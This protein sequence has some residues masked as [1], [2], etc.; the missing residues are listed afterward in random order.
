MFTVKSFSAPWLG[1]SSKVFLEPSLGTSGLGYYVGV[2][3]K[4]SLGIFTWGQVNDIKDKVI[5]RDTVVIPETTGD[6]ISQNLVEDWAYGVSVIFSDGKFGEYTTVSIPLVGLMNDNLGA[7]VISGTAT[8][9]IKHDRFA[10]MLEDHKLR[11]LLTELKYR[12]FVTL[13]FDYHGNLRAKLLGLPWYGH[14][15]I[16][17]LVKKRGCGTGE[18]IKRYVER[19]MDCEFVEAW[20]VG[21]LLSCFPFPA[22]SHGTDPRLV[23][24]N[25]DALKHFYP[26]FDV[27]RGNETTSNVLGVA[28]GW[29]FEGYSSRLHK[30]CEYVS[31][32]CK[33]IWCPEVQY[34][35]DLC[36]QFSK[37]WGEIKD[38]VQSL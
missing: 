23:S 24:F 32:T 19:P 4:E 37:Q 5:L 14:Y 9:G 31:K 18:R 11:A 13:M 22:V 25:D 36:E 1:L 33:N 38:Q 27:R 7:K 29:S 26:L 3:E 21:V 10:P 28:V 15:T 20:S 12:G 6:L 16:S 35:T 34:R 2:T 8:R 17:S 30:A